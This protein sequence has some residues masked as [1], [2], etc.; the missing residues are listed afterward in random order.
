MAP[1]TKFLVPGAIYYVILNPKLRIHNTEKN[2]VILIKG[3]L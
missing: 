1:G 3:S 2:Y